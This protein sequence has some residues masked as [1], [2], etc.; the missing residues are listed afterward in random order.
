MLTPENMA[1]A[2]AMPAVEA[3]AGQ[4]LADEEDPA[5]AAEREK[6]QERAKKNAPPPP[7]PQDEKIKSLV[8]A[9]SQA[10]D[11]ERRRVAEELVAKVKP[12]YLA[13]KDGGRAGEAD[14]YLKT[15][16]SLIEPLYLAA[17]K[18]GRKADEDYYFSVLKSLIP[19][20]EPPKGIGQKSDDPQPGK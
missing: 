17:E 3:G 6:L 14:Y 12:L 9:R 19:S 1:A 11:D 2:S 15:I 16:K 5:I 18:E 10:L 13:A 4:P 8:T 7:N 20:Y